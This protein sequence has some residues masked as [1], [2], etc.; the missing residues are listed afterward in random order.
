MTIELSDIPE[1]KEYA[2][3][4]VMDD[5]QRAGEALDACLATVRKQGDIHQLSYLYH[6]MGKLNFVI[7]DIDR[8]FHFFEQAESVD[9]GS[10]ATKQGFLRF[11]VESPKLYERAIEESTNFINTLLAHPQ[12]EGSGELGS[13]H[14]LSATYALQG[15]CYALLSNTDRACSNLR[16]LIDINTIGSPGYAIK[17]CELLIDKQSCNEYIAKYLDFILER[18]SDADSRY[19]EFREKVEVLLKRI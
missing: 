9:P 17:L 15:Y 6:L 19:S 10:P 8:A 1:Y 5:Y 4:W 13:D 3:A 12:E 7:G 18:L 2:R 11:L 16:Q 14:Y